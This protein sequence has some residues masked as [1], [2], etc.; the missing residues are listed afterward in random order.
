MPVQPESAPQLPPKHH[1]PRPSPYENSPYVRM[2]RQEEPFPY[3]PQRQ[4]APSQ[5]PGKKSG[6]WMEDQQKMMNRPSSMPTIT[7]KAGSLLRYMR[8][9]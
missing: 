9:A 7:E 6:F 4:P 5:T 8:M 2:P 1:S 3:T